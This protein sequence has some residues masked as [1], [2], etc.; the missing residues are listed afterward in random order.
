MNFVVNLM[1]SNISEQIKDWK[2]IEP[3][4]VAPT[5]PLMNRQCMH[6]VVNELKAKRAFAI[7]EV[8]GSGDA[9]AHYLCVA[10]NGDIYDPTLGWNWSGCKYKLVRYIHPEYDG[11][12]DMSGEL[13]KL[14][15]RVYKML[16][17]HVRL[18]SRVTLTNYYNVF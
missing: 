14:K 1:R 7:I 9:I 17:W 18:L 13:D 3:I 4:N 16:P 8:V 11:I 15:L 5:T 12:C 6:N 10:E 2:D